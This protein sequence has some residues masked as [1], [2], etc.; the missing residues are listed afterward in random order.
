MKG[1]EIFFV[2]FL[3]WK[4]DEGGYPSSR[5]KTAVFAAIDP[6]LELDPMRRAAAAWPTPTTCSRN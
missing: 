6:L 5:D 2:A 3:R 4:R 1:E